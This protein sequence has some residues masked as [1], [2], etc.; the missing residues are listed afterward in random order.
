MSILGVNSIFTGAKLEKYLPQS[1]VF[2]RE[3]MTSVQ[4]SKRVCGMQCASHEQLPI[5][6]P[7]YGLVECLTD[8]VMPSPSQSTVQLYQPVPSRRLQQQEQQAD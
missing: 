4:H 8:M 5:W 3:G 2:H 7:G 6:V 1:C